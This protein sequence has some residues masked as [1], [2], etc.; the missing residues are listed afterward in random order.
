MSSSLARTAALLVAASTSFILTA[1]AHHGDGTCY[2]PAG[3]VADNNV[4]C[5]PDAAVSSCCSEQSFCLAN[6]LC[7]VNNDPDTVEFARGACTD[8]TFEDPACFQQCH[9][10]TLT[11]LPYASETPFPFYTA[12][13]AIKPL[14]TAIHLLTPIHSATWLSRH[15]RRRSL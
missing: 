3:N 14:D 15:E 2:F 7:L 12:R 11:P 10:C 4:P 6:G 9:G 1:S 5:N 8:P 13:P